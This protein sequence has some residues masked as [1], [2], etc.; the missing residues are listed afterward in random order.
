[1]D[2]GS[3]V[4]EHEE[5]AAGEDYKDKA[6]SANTE[7]LRSEP[8]TRRSS[9]SGKVTEK[10]SVRPSGIE[11][12]KGVSGVNETQKGPAPKQ[13]A[14][15]FR[16]LSRVVVAELSVYKNVPPEDIVKLWSAVLTLIGFRDASYDSNMKTKAVWREIQKRLITASTN[17]QHRISSIYCCLKEVEKR[18]QGQPPDATT[19]KVVRGTLPKVDRVTSCSKPAEA[20]HVWVISALDQFTKEKRSTGVTGG[21]L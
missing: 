4:N 15:T 13:P 11:E 8:S 1:M 2:V 17:Q 9:T 10:G 20:L 5:S 19:V 6:S 3:W 7:L 12:C 21:G 18:I 14:P 16:S